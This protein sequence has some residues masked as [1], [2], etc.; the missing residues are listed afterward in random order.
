MLKFLPVFLAVSAA[1]CPVNA[2]EP[3]INQAAHTQELL[4]VVVF[5]RHG[6]RPPTQSAKTLSEWSTHEWPDW[7][8]PA[9]YLTARGF[10]LVK[11]TW[12]LNRKQ[13]PFTYGVCPSPD[14]VQ[15]IADVD[16]RTKKT[17]EAIIA[18]LYPQCGFKVQFNSGKKSPLFSPLKAKVCEIEDKEALASDLSARATAVANEYGEAIEAIGKITGRSFMGAVTADV[19]KH[20][21]RMNGAP[22]DAASIAEIFA[23]EWGQWPGQRVAWGELDWKGI[24]PLMPFRVAMFSSLNKDWQVAHYRGSALAKKIIDSLDHGPKY[25]FLVGHDTNLA[26]LGK[27]FDL[28]WK[29]PDRVKDE[30]TPG[31]YLVFEKWLVN[32]QTNL[33][34]TYSALSPEQIHAKE[35]TEPAVETTVIKGTDFEAWKKTYSRYV[36]GNCVIP[37]AI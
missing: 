12:E 30:N 36:Y 14:Q 18:G 28:N 11:K 16:E 13:S 23:L 9:G 6:V 2:Q 35:V 26:N 10:E 29:L 7:G 8:A 3:T 17:A 24:L 37:G 27:F 32:G 21:I 22:Y 1:A 25:T 5:S 4:N 15:V 20:K 33:R 31:G 34:V 19:S